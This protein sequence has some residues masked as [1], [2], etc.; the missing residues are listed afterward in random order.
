MYMYMHNVHVQVHAYV[1]HSGHKLDH[2][3]NPQTQTC[4]KSW[5]NAYFHKGALSCTHNSLLYTSAFCT[6][7]TQTLERQFNTTQ[8]SHFQRKISCPWHDW[9]C[10][11]RI[12]YCAHIT[13]ANKL[14]VGCK[15]FMYVCSW[16]KFRKQWQ[17]PYDK[18]VNTE[19]S[20]L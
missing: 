16:R 1:C 8:F 9:N 11:F 18:W 17:F 15:P 10:H 19:R 20:W 12:W 3:H 7:N 5:A 13:Q 6:W 2:F 4:R 14:T